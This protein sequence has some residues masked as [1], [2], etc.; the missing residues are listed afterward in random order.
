ME[1]K[2][3]NKAAELTAKAQKIVVFTGAGVSTE[4]GIPDFRS[5]GGIWSRYDPELF[6]YQ[7]FMSS[8]QARKKVW[9]MLRETFLQF[10]AEPN[11]AHKAIADLFAHGCLYGVIT[12]N[13]DG[14]HQESGIPDDFIFELHG[15]MRRVKCM[16]CDQ[17][18]ETERIKN[19]LFKEEIPKCDHCGGI[20]KPGVVFFGE[21][22]PINVLEEACYRARNCDLFIVVGSSLRVYPAA[23]IPKYALEAGTPIIVINMT[24]TYLD[25]EA[26]VVLRGKAGEIMSRIVKLALEKKLS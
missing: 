10:H 12:Q 4:S 1:H 25:A 3:L 18:Y 17:L 15:N 22:L 23:N 24:P 20:L 16:N 5:P 21:V 26:D 6:T 2:D 14:L 19:K 7:Y 9:A 13:I 11:A 8:S